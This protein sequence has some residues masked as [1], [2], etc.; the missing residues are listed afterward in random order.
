MLLEREIILT[1]E[2]YRR[3]KEE[4]DYLSTKKREEVAERIR[5]SRGFGDIS[6]NSEYDDAKNEQAML[7]AR[8]YALEEKLASARVI[9][10]KSVKTDVVNVGTKVTL[11]NME[12]GDVVQ[13]SIVGSAEADPT[14]HKLSN[15]SPVGRAIMGGKTGDKVS[16]QAPQKAMKFKII[17]IERA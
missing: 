16:V 1:P 10:A 7:E 17:A 12:T 2:G 6:E 8:I 9:D 3:L 11:Q 4:I 15:E 14:T 5:E 13:Y